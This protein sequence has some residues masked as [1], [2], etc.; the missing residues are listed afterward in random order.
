MSHKVRWTAQ[1]IAQRLSLIEPLAYRARFPLLYWTYLFMTGLLV[2]TF[3]FF[4]LHTLLWLPRS[5]VER[6][7]RQRGHHEER[8]P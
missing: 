5:L 3:A 6:L 2:F 7:R 4:G 8:S 1:K